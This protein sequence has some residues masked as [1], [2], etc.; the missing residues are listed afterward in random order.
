[1]LIL[2]TKKIRI[3]IILSFSLSLLVSCPKKNEQA[4]DI[5]F[6]QP[7]IKKQ[8][9]ESFVE[10]QFK[11]LS[12]IIRFSASVEREIFK[13]IRTNLSPTMTQFEVLSAI[14]DQNLGI[15]KNFGSVD[16]KLY[17]IKRSLKK[18]D[19]YKQCLSPESLIA[20]I[21]FNQNKATIHFYT[22]EWAYA[23]GASVALAGKDRICDIQFSQSKLNKLSC[24]QTQLML[25]QTTD[26]EELRLSEF[27]FD[28]SATDQVHVTGG[29]YKNLTEHRKLKLNIPFDGKIKIIEKELKVQD[30]FAEQKPVIIEAVK[31]KIQDIIKT[32]ENNGEKNNNQENNQENSTENIENNQQGGQ[33]TTTPETGR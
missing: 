24:E 16:C 14:L 1:M 4:A 12:T 19:F 28:Q 32:E 31:N 15:K 2:F 3:A 13:T 17:K 30:D 8:N 9:A 22:K 20:T 5:K 10:V 21:D 7:E 18:I 33:P 25:A 23:V 29:F 26:I 11:Q 27:I 6:V